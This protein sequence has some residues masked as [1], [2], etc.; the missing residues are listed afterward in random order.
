LLLGSSPLEED[1]LLSTPGLDDDAM[2]GSISGLEQAKNKTGNKTAAAMHK[3]AR[4][5]L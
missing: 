3:N 1:S 2:F 5:L 4:T